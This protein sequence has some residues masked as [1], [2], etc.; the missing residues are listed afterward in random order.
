[1]IYRMKTVS[2]W[3]WKHLS[4]QN[5]LLVSAQMVLNWDKSKDKISFKGLSCIIFKGSS[6]LN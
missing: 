1:M 4:R 2:A 3:K 5:K 6:E